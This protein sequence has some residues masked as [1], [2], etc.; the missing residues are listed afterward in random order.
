MQQKDEAVRQLQKLTADATHWRSKY[1][2]DAIGKIEELE[3]TKLKLQ[4]RL[5]E[6]EGTMENLNSKL[7]ALEKA[8]LIVTKDIEDVSHR[9][10]QVNVV[11]N[12][13]E[14]RVKLM[15]KA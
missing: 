10:D 1:E 13:A 11:F 7:M 14:K 2:V 5:A 4:A 6:S 3:M 12:Q 9:V 15:D 8:K